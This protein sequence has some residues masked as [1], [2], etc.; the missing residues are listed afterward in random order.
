MKLSR[1]IEATGDETG[2]DFE[3][4]L[5]ELWCAGDVVDPY[6]GDKMDTGVDC[7]ST[8]QPDSSAFTAVT[9]QDG[10]L[11][12]IKQE[13]VDLAEQLEGNHISEYSQLDF[14]MEWAHTT[15]RYLKLLKH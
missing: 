13:D 12:Y 15:I 11:F 5:V 1:T 14:N 4:D 3:V 9:D 6:P 10:H 2:P 8:S 7:S